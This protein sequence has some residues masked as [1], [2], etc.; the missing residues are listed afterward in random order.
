MFVETAS[1][2]TDFFQY[3]FIQKAILAGSFVALCCSILGLFLVL[4]RFSMMGDGLAHV[5]FGVIGLGLLLGVQPVYFSIPLV[6]LASL[7][8]LRLSE[9]SEMH[10]DA[11]I[12]LT[13]SLGLAGGVMLAS[14]ASG[15]NVDLFSYLFGNILVI[16]SGE[17]ILSVA[18]SVVVLL[19]VALFFNDLFVITFE[20]E[21]ARTLGIRT[22]LINSGL[23]LCT[24][25]T[26]VL[27]IRVVGTL[28]VSSLIVFPA[29]TAL[30]VASS[31]KAALLLASLSSVLSVWLGILISFLLDLPTGATIVLVN[32]LFFLSASGYARFSNR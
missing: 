16:S 25:L 13:S 22:H 32:F 30:Q 21:Y 3:A 20:E 11:A 24:A 2:L 9:R 28:L 8:I 31:F 14:L 10:G 7:W 23:V 26:V 18:L 29:V 5:S 4:R 27:G 12:G 15:F 17:V 19:A 6:M 1:E